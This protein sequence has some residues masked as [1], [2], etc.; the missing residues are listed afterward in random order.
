MIAIHCCSHGSR[1]LNN[2]T[3]LAQKPRVKRW[4]QLVNTWDARFGRALGGEQ[5][6]QL[7]EQYCLF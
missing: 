7:R 1:N 2:K 4:W 6:V 3:P 5:D